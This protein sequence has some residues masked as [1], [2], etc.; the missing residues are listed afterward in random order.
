MLLVTARRLFYP[1]I[2]ILV[3]LPATLAQAD[4][5]LDRVLKKGVLRVA[6]SVDQPP[7]NMRNKDNEI[8]GFDVDLAKTL[9]KVMQVELEIVEMP[10]SE[11]LP[12]IPRGKADMAI[13]GL[14][15]TPERTQKV[16]F[17]GPYLL[18]GKSIITTERIKNVVQGSE[19]FNDPEIRVVALEGSTSEIF[20]QRQL[21]NAAFHSIANYNE[22]IEML[23]TGAVDAM[24]ADV[25]R[26]K[27]IKLRYPEAALG[28]LEPQLS[29]EPLG[30]AISRK[31]PQFENL[32]RNYLHGMEQA[33]FIPRLRK[34][35]FEDDSWIETLP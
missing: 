31:D 2:L 32:L 25:P 10:F 17:V 28:I 33:G 18:S 23:L 13:S 14:T 24:V 35:W 3:M 1:L 21:P 34:T 4:A 8:V 30:I 7:Y 22:G 5:V 9:A 6:M 26:L 19:D 11:L 16:S 12:S 27:L 15:I 29:V 20:A